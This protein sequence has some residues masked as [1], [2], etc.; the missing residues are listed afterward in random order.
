MIEKTL[1]LSTAHIQQSTSGFLTEIGN[2]ENDEVP[3]RFVDHQYGYIIFVSS[4]ILGKDNISD[5]AEYAQL[6]ENFPDLYNLIR[7]A[8]EN[9][10]TM[11]NLDRDG[12]TIDDLPTFEW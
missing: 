8:A 9:G 11:I 12:D 7:Y 2:N 5:A 4:S 10:C 3:F 1:V 6:L